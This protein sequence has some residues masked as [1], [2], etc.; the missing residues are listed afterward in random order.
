MEKWKLMTGKKKVSYKIPCAKGSQ[1][2]KKKIHMYM[3]RK[4][5]EEYALEQ[6]SSVLGSKNAMS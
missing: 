5:M 2:L 3:H 4:S 1:S 6:Y